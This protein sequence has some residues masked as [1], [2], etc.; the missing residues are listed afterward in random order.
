M[1]RLTAYINREAA[2]PSEGGQIDIRSQTLEEP[3]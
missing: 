1:D 3:W 2:T